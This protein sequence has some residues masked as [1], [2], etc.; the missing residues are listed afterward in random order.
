MSFQN[1]SKKFPN[2]F[3][4]SYQKSSRKSSRK[5]PQTRKSERIVYLVLG[6][7]EDVGP[8]VDVPVAG[9]G[10]DAL[11]AGEDVLELA[12]NFYPAYKV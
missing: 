4:K 12:L 11:G 6:L 5:V 8:V 2:K 9:Q 10:N 1:S 7:L 3:P